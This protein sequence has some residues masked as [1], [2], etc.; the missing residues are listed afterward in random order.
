MLKTKVIAIIGVVVMVIGLIIG[1][2]VYVSV[3][4]NRH[5]KTEYSSEQAINKILDIEEIHMA[6]YPYN[7]KTERIITKENKKGKLKKYC[8]Y[9][10]T[11]RG[12]VQIGT[13]EK[14]TA[15]VD[16]EAKVI[17]VTIPEPKIL[18]ISID[19][20]SIDYIFNKKK[21]E[22]EIVAADSYKLCL[23]DLESNIKTDKG[24]MKKAKK[25]TENLV[26]ALLKP[27]SNEYKIKIN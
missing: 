15:S 26:V 18:D 9:H 22:T 21:Y 17:S 25:N 5:E 10:V 8:L 2:C 6:N 7:G 12:C 19:F 23:D 27:F 11:Y 3:Q 4:T 24:L 14:L 1:F 13:T 20:N 16:E